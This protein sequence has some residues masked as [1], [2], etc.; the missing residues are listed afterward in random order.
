MLRFT[1][2]I[3]FLRHSLILL[4]KEGSYVK[5]HDKDWFPETFPYFILQGGVIGEPWFP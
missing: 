3:G 4:F 1:I 2:K 5:I